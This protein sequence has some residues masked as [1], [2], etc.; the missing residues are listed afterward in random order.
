[1]KPFALLLCVAATTS[2]W[3]SPF[4]RAEEPAAIVSGP[5]AAAAVELA[6]LTIR[7]DGSIDGTIINRSGTEIEDVDLLVSHTWSWRDER[8]P[9]DDDP[10]R[11]THI[12]LAALIP[13][14][15]SL[16]FSYAP[17]PS[18]PVRPDGSFKTTAT[19]RSFSEVRH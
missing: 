16:A 4:A 5:E 15:G 17:D 10:G 3:S 9:G 13:S 14:Q 1:M 18:L 7:S 6:G 8:H 19:V 12:R 11:A 2:L